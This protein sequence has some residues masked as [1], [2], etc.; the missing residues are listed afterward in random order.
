MPRLP[1]HRPQATTIEPPIFDRAVPDNERYRFKKLQR[2]PLSELNESEIAEYF[3][4]KRK[5][6]AIAEKE[7]ILSTKE[8]KERFE[9]K[10]KA[11]KEWVTSGTNAERF[12]VSSLFY[13]QTDNQYCS[14]KT[15]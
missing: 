3:T 9:A 1:V 7:R 2:T 4:L 10:K 11:R 14:T 6:E 5:Y 12:L 13:D 15:F 8:L